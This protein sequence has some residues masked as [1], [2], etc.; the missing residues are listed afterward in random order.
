VLLV[1][2]D[3]GP[4]GAERQILALMR[5]LGPRFEAH[6]CVFRADLHY[7]EALPAGEPR[8]VL[9]RARMGPA[10]LPALEAIIRAERPAIVQTFRDEAN[11]WGR[12]AALRAG[13]PVIVGSVRTR[14]LAVEN[15]V[16]ERWLA[17]RTCAVTTNSMGVV[18]ELVRRARVPT[19]KILVIPNFIDIG[20]F[21][22]PTDDERRT[23]RRRLGIPGEAP[24]WVLPGRV[25]VQKNQLGLVRALGRLAASGRSPPG[26]RIVLAGRTAPRARPYAWLAR[27][28]AGRIEGD[29]TIDWRAAEADARALYHAADALVLPSLW[30][31]MPNALLEAMACGLPAVASRAANLDEVLED[32]VGGFEFRRGVT[33]LATALERLAGLSSEARAAMGRANRA[34]IIERFSSERTAR[35]WISLYETHLA[36][37]RAAPEGHGFAA[38]A[39]SP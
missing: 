15:L 22:P 5:A 6:L 38:V 25:C 10:A 26:L 7:R 35:A 32:G 8:H 9:G 19:E 4:G 29:V 27:R 16:T 39:L 28:A 37:A 3:L 20:A 36:A 34:R 30:E 21:Q 24:T 11:L 14:Q 18:G 2:P 12:L 33:G 1:I 13:V 17:Q 23:A 31:G